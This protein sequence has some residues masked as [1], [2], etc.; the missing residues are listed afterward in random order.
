MN[1]L[2]YTYREMEEEMCERFNALKSRLKARR[3][4]GLTPSHDANDGKVSV[5]PI[6][7][8]AIPIAIEPPHVVDEA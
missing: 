5:L 4:D 6:A 8:S 2:R 7:S 3:Q 1:H